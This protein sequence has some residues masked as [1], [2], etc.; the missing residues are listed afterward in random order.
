[1]LLQDSD[2]VRDVLKAGLHVG[3]WADDSVTTMYAFEALCY[4]KNGYQMCRVR[5]NIGAMH[6]KDLCEAGC[7]QD[8][9]FHFVRLAASSESGPISK[10]VQRRSKLL[11][12]RV[13]LA[14]RQVLIM[15]AAPLKLS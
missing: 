7:S 6:Q 4:Q 11:D 8:H 10:Q 5:E 13:D 14:E 12:L 2:G 15:V 1:M 3:R 9:S